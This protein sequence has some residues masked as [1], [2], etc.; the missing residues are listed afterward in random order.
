MGSF[1]R[2]MSEHHSTASTSEVENDIYQLL[3]DGYIVII[4]LSVG[5]AKIR[6]SISERIARNIFRRSMSIFHQG[7]HGVFPAG[8]PGEVL[9]NLQVY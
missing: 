9:L 5:H 1:L 2:P 8:S 3:V 4:D 7:N 6:E